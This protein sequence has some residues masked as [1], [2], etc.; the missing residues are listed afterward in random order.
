MPWSAS[1]TRSMV[2][3]ISSGSHPSAI[4]ARRCD[5]TPPQKIGHAEPATLSNSPAPMPDRASAAPTSASSCSSDD[6]DRDAGQLA[7][8]VEGGDVA[9]EVVD[10]HAGHRSAERAAPGRAGRTTHARRTQGRAE[11]R[12]APS[13]VSFHVETS[14]RCPAHRWPSGRCAGRR[15]RPHRVGRADCADHRRRPPRSPSTSWPAGCCWRRWPN[16]THTSTR[17]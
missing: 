3:M 1:R 14:P 7:G 12:G 13:T 8:C 16:P 10:G 5:A 15:R 4:A 6:L 17:R 2:S 11:H 9:A